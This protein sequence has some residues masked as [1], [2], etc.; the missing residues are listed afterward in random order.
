LLDRPVS[1]AG[2]FAGDGP[3]RL[4][5]TDATVELAELREALSGEPVNHGPAVFTASMGLAGAIAAHAQFADHGIEPPDILTARLR[6]HPAKSG[7]RD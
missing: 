1:M 3:V 7:L 2:L 5:G 4:T 6:E